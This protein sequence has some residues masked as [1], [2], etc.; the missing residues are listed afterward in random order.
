[1]TDD[2]GW[3]LDPND[4]MIIV[5]KKNGTRVMSLFLGE[6]MESAGRKNILKHVKE[7]DNSPWLRCWGADDAIIEK[8]KGKNE[9]LE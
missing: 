6:A 4:K 5:I 1:M 9:I 3:D 7:C 8:L 2:Y